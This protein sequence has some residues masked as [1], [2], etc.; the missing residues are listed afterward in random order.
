MERLP[1][2]EGAYRLC[3]CQ[4]TGGRTYSQPHSN[5]TI[6]Q[7][8][9]GPSFTPTD[10]LKRNER[11]GVSRF[12]CTQTGKAIWSWLAGWWSMSMADQ[13]AAAVDTQ[14]TADALHSKS[15]IAWPLIG[16]FAARA[17]T[18]SL[19]WGDGSI[20]AATGNSC[21]YRPPATTFA[22]ATSRSATVLF[23]QSLLLSAGV[24]RCTASS[25]GRHAGSA[26]KK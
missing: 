10:R 22:L 15:A 21:R 12:R 16:V 25:A 6:W 24:Y 7:M 17:A 4:I 1:Q 9:L 23:P 5:G 20:A 13:P 8:V 18:T 11:S 14:L 3:F 26:L 19:Q 2:A